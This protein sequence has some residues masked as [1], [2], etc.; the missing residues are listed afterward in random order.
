[1]KQKHS[2]GPFGSQA[3]GGQ[4]DSQK[5]A[6]DHYRWAQRYTKYGEP[7]KARAHMQRALHY[8]RFGAPE[9]TVK[10][11][12]ESLETPVDPVKELNDDMK[13]L[14]RAML[15]EDLTTAGVTGDKL[16]ELLG[17]VEKMDHGQLMAC[18][19]SRMSPGYD[20][21]CVMIAAMLMHKRASTTSTAKTQGMLEYD[22]EARAEFLTKVGSIIDGR[23]EFDGAMLKGGAETMLV[24][25]DFSTN[26]GDIDDAFAL[27]VLAHAAV[28]AGEQCS[29]KRLTVVLSARQKANGDLTTPESV[30]AWI[31]ERFTDRDFHVKMDTDKPGFTVEMCN[32]R[33]DVCWDLGR[34]LTNKVTDTEKS[35]IRERFGDLVVG[36]SRAA[37]VL[38]GPISRDTADVLLKLRKSEKLELLVGVTVSSGVNGGESV[39]NSADFDPDKQEAACAGGKK[40]ASKILEL[41]TAETRPLLMTRKFLATHNLLSAKLLPVAHKSAWR[42]FV[43]FYD[44]NG[45]DDKNVDMSFRL[46]ASNSQSSAPIRVQDVVILMT[47]VY[48]RVLRDPESAAYTDGYYDKILSN[49]AEL[50]GLRSAHYLRIARLYVAMCVAN[51]G[52][53][54][55]LL[56]EEGN[57]LWDPVYGSIVEGELPEGFDGPLVSAVASEGSARDLVV[58]AIGHIGGARAAIAAGAAG[59]AVAAG[60]AGASGAAGAA[61]FARHVRALYVTSVLVTYMRLLS[62]GVHLLKFGLSL[63]SIRSE[64]IEQKGTKV[65]ADRKNK[66]LV[67][68]DPKAMRPKRRFPGP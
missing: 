48:S 20:V 18:S 68:F 61:E 52:Y 50:N 66:C 4:N 9:D 59:A 60:A 19:L 56:S 30:C 21:A 44:S 42:A 49:V 35:K 31:A 65:M 13:K 27:G 6:Y 40:I 26:A 38:I 57:A 43:G 51:L 10:P 16:Q 1:M 14:A 67:I 29:L 34:A 22:M 54:R 8:S 45:D 23:D 53:K 7:E 12:P 47:D 2:A 28:R 11:N 15:E 24:F 64:K 36:G 32:L 55:S 58:K 37:A 33:V 63:D 41:N 39:T 3:S 46:I 17:S 5:R 25:T 62:A